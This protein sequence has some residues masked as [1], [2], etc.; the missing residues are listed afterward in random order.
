MESSAYNSSIAYLRQLDTEVNAM[1]PTDREVFLA[2]IKVTQDAWMRS[3]MSR[4]PHRDDE[5]DPTALR[6][7]PRCAEA[8]R[9]PEFKRRSFA[10][11]NA[12]TWCK[13]C[14]NAAARERRRRKRS[15][16]LTSLGRR[17]RTGTRVTRTEAV[18]AETIRRLGGIEGFGKATA[19]LVQKCVGRRE[20]LSAFRLVW[21]MIL[22]AR[23]NDRS[24]RVPHA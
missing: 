20:S 3:A 1:P 10:Q 19:D 2:E 5:I 8:K 21:Q 6:T 7:C 15:A 9:L 13:E 24:E 23:D 11:G 17:L 4:R 22:A 14:V 18:V 12:P 16:A